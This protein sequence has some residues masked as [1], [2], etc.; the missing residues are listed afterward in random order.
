MAMHATGRISFLTAGPTETRAWLLPLGG[1][2]LDAAGQVHT[3][4]QRG[5]VR[6]ERMRVDE[7]LGAGSEAKVREQGKLALLGK[8]HV[9]ADG[10]ILHILAST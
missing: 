9:I 7:L 4:F 6:A 8:E 1:T 2:A 5:F 10:D 3:D